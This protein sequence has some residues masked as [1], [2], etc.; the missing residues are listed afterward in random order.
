MGLLYIPFR[1]NFYSFEHDTHYK[2]TFSLER[3]QLC[4]RF[5]SRVI[6]R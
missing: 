3:R 2:L 4:A 1:P 5:A 6:G